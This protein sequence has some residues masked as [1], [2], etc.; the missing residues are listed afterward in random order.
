MFREEGMPSQLLSSP[1]PQYA[2]LSSTDIAREEI[3]YPAVSN[4]ASIIDDRGSLSASASVSANPAMKRMVAELVGSE[5]TYD[6][7]LPD[8]SCNYDEV[9]RAPPTPPS[10][11]FDDDSPFGKTNDETSYGLLGNESAY[12]PMDED[13]PDHPQL[14]TPRFSTLYTYPMA[15]YHG[16][17]ASSRPNTA[18]RLSFPQQQPDD[19]GA[20]SNVA[21][22]H[23]PPYPSSILSATAAPYETYGHGHLTLP[24]SIAT[25]YGPNGE[26]STIW[27][28]GGSTFDNSHF[29]SPLM[30][31]ESL[32]AFNGRTP[33][34]GQAGG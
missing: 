11:S 31:D 17:P 14:S 29:I 20:R 10:H 34:N 28:N 23:S 9:P 6:A 8:I 33:P 13:S 3:S 7:D 2:R 15:S 18:T 25:K 5:A 22:V 24:E 19:C 30:F 4:A 27:G 16:E 26:A 32:K 1:E 21:S 12:D